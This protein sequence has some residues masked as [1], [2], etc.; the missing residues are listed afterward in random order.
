MTRDWQSVAAVK[1]AAWGIPVHDSMPTASGTPT[2]QVTV[3]TFLVGWHEM[4]VRI[5]YVTGNPDH[6]RWLRYAQ[7]YVQTERYV[8]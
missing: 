4:G 3:E 1:A 8:K 5:V 6:N 2:A 7:D